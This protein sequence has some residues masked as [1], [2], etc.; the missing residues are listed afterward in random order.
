MKKR[1]DNSHFS[2]T[3]KEEIALREV[4]NQYSDN[5]SLV[6]V[7]HKAQD[8]YGYLPYEVMK[9][10]SDGLNITI[11]EVYSV[12]TFYTQFRLNRSGKYQIGVCLGTACYI[13]GSDKIILEIKNILGIGDGECTN[14]GLFSLDTTRC[15]GCCGMAPVIKINDDVYGNVN[16]SDVERI[17]NSYKVRDEKK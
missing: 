13:K 10:I 17:L 8:I 14:D 15:L 4:L 7:L 5:G 11:N 2:G 12:A 16:V 3:K 9:M 6:E 1:I